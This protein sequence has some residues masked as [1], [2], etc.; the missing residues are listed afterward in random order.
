MVSLQ[1]RLV[2][3]ESNNVYHDDEQ[4]GAIA[5]LDH[6]QEQPAAFANTE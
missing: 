2:N 5:T 3:N 4:Q 1:S 6:K